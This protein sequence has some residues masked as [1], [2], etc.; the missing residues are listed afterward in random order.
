M[1]AI[2]DSER[3]P[4]PRI[5]SR[6]RK[7]GPFAILRGRWTE[8]EPLVAPPREAWPLALRRIRLVGFAVLGIELVA[9]CWWGA[10]LAHRFDLTADFAT[11]A[12][13]MYQIS[14]GTLLP[15]QTISNISVV[16]GAFELILWPLAFVQAIWPHAVT[17][18]ILPA[19][20]MVGAQGIALAWICDIVA[21]GAIRDRFTTA[22]S[23]G[24]VGLGVLLLVADPWYA[25][26]LSFD[27]H[28][29]PFMV[30]ALVATARDLFR[31][32][33]TAWIWALLL[34]ICSAVGAT[35][36][37]A[38][39]IGAAASGR[40]RLRRGL[41]MAL[42]GLAWLALVAALHAETYNSG[43]F[44]QLVA[45][46]RHFSLRGA[47]SSSFDVIKAVI[48]HPGRAWSI[49]W[50][51]RIN[52]WANVSAPGILGL[53]WPPALLASVFQ[54]LETGFLPVKSGFSAPGF[55]DNILAEPLIT[56]GTVALCAALLGNKRYR[57]VVAPLA[58]VLAANTVL[59][60]VV[61]FP[62]LVTRWLTVSSATAST[63]R[64]VEAR[65]GPTD[66]VVASQGV[67]GAFAYRRWVYDLP[68]HQPVHVHA[69]RVWL[70]VT[71]RAGIETLL[72]AESYA[73]IST[74]A[75]LPGSHLVVA[76]NG[77]WAFEWNPPAGTKTV[78][79]ATTDTSIPAWTAGGNNG[80]NVQRGKRSN[81]YTASTVKPGYALSGD[82]W[83]EPAGNYVA[84]VS[85]AVAAGSANVNVEV[86]DASAKRLLVRRVL[87]HTNGRTTVHLPVGVRTARGEGV[88]RGWGAWSM[89][90][91]APFP[92]DNLE[93]RVWSPGGVG[94]VKVY[95][96]RMRVRD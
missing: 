22:A 64:K 73:D 89:T 95:S 41:S 47:Q 18:K 15:V 96:A 59:W 20:A 67:V 3:L 63:L 23:V 42:F 44:Q 12:N 94:R 83:R 86:W 71:P 34:C 25:F 90:P 54:S 43:I 45:G 87:Q 78:A 28:P 26:N 21:A 16:R 29:E 8:A 58:V 1:S 2:S 79:M 39:G 69:R 24:L 77:V 70:I 49:L 57:R 84:S 66:E 60:G 74:I 40:Y 52:I 38:L 36:L 62:N 55:T 61:W 17:L 85:L 82:Y 7:P 56:I 88:F 33:R 35:Y 72:T 65:I 6:E 46:A 92:G 91:A 27:F 80:H 10:L 75:D 9:L 37:I 53:F 13:A 76:Q 30:L 48:E 14:H 19:L 11:Y 5:G 50:P 31:H 51:N 4:R 93:I 32:R 81:W 68:Y